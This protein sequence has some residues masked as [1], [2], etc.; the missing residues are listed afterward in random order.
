MAEDKKEKKK[1][2]TQEDIMKMLDMY[3]E[4]IFLDT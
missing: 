4:Y 2:V 1:L 3:W